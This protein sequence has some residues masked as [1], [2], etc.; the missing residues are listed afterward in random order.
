MIKSIIFFIPGVTWTI[1]IKLFVRMILLNSI[2]FNTGR[3]KNNTLFLWYSTADT[4]SFPRCN[5]FYITPKKLCCTNNNNLWC[6]STCNKTN[7]LGT[8]KWIF[9]MPQMTV[10][11]YDVFVF[12]YNFILIKWIILGIK[13]SVLSPKYVLSKS[14]FF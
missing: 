9:L 12:P 8:R 14:H 1:V 10:T 3:C 11:I 7:N 2:W 4:R 13:V 6:D 5:C